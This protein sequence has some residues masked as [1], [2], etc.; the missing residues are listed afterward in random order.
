M[1]TRACGMSTVVLQRHLV[2]PLLPK[3]LTVHTVAVVIVKA[4]STLT[5]AMR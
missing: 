2:H 5:Q 3:V 4:V 1:K